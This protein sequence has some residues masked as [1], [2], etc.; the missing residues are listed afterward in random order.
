M[1]IKDSG[2]ILLIVGALV[3]FQLPSLTIG[4]AFADGVRNRASLNMRQRLKMRHQPAPAP[5]AEGQDEPSPPKP[6]AGEMGATVYVC[7]MHPEVV[8]DHPGDCPKC[9]M[10]LVPKQKG[11]PGPDAGMQTDEPMRHDHTHHQ[12]GMERK[13]SASEPAEGTDEPRQPRH[14]HEE[15]H[16]HRAMIM[17]PPAS[18]GKALATIRPADSD[19]PVTYVCPMHP[20]IHQDHPGKCPICGMDLVAKSAHSHPAQEAHP[21][22]FVSGAMIQSLGVRTALVQRGSVSREFKAQGIVAPDDERI[23]YLHP[24]AAGWIETLYVRTDGEEVERSDTLADFY[25]PYITQVQ[26]DYL[27]ALEELDLASFD[28]EGR[29]Q[30]Q[31]KANALRNSL[32]NLKVMDLDIKRIET[33]RTVLPTIQIIA[34]QDGVISELGVREGMYVEPFD[35][36]FTIVDLSQVWV[37]V[38]LH[39]DQAAWIRPGQQMEITAPAVPGKHWTGKVEYI[40]PQVDP[41]TRTLRARLEIANPNE[42]LLLNMFVEVSLS[43]DKAADSL[44]IPRQAIILTGERKSVVKDLGNGHFQPVDVETGMWDDNH[45]EI[46]SG[47][48]EGDRIVVSGQF[49]IDSESSIQASFLRMAE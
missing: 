43:G 4:P 48:K 41:R 20:Q 10:H 6:V 26:L 11:R 15:V 39:E 9:G 33:S 7:P 1:S 46:L 8:S 2:F 25:S 19:H 17:Q 36:M 21:Q 22:V 45:I 18:T 29:K 31:I 44:I 34:P 49:L 12:M 30:S 38:D 14:E 42:S 37:M 5:M 40:Y 23:T 28:P 47:L 35:R 13:R 24:R 32:R 3:C 27:K 16:S